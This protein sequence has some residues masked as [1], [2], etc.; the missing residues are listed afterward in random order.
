MV[1]VVCSTC[2]Y[3]VERALQDL[4]YFDALWWGVVTMTT[5]G[6]GDY[7]AQTFLGR[8]FDFGTEYVYRDSVIFVYDGLCIDGA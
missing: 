1:E 8:F 3:F 4:T 7:Y 6:Y 2:F 5:V